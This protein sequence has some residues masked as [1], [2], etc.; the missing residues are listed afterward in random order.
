[1]DSNYPDE[2]RQYVQSLFASE[3]EVLS[4]IGESAADAGLPGISIGAEEGRF[5]QL[6][7]TAVGASR[8]LEIGTLAG[9]SGIWLAR[10]LKPDGE[11]VTLEQE[12][13]HAEV[14]ERMFDAAG[15]AGRVTIMTGPALESLPQLVGGPAFDVV[16]IDADKQAY[17]EYL[18]WALQL[19]RPGAAILAHNTFMGGRVARRGGDEPVAAMREFNRRLAEDPRLLSTLVPLRDGISLSIVREATTS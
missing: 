8:A 13:R 12:S 18:D 11:L 14:A 10:G 7:A 15:L 2:M 19:A 4:R 6:V 17:P 16:F 3:D 5:L 9:Y 1:M